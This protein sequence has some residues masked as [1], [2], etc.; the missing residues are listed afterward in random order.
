MPSPRSVRP[1]ALFSMAVAMAACGESAPPATDAGVDA[2]GSPTEFEDAAAGD[3]GSHDAGEPIDAPTDEGD[4]MTMD[5]GL[6]VGSALDGAGC[7]GTETC[8]VFDDDCDGRIDETACVP[9]TSALRT[10]CT[11]QRLADG[12]VLLA[13]SSSARLDG[14]DYASRFCEELGAGYVAATIDTAS[15]PARFAGS[16]GTARGTFY[17]PIFRLADGTFVDE[18]GTP[19]D[20]TSI[21]ALEWVDGA[22]GAVSLQRRCT[23]LHDDGLLEDVPCIALSYDH[24]AL[25]IGTPP[26]SAPSCTPATE[27]CDGLDDDCDLRVDERACDECTPANFLGHRYAMCAFGQ[28]ETSLRRNYQNA[29]ADCR[30]RGGSLVTFET[31]DE[32]VAVARRLRIDPSSPY[33][34]YTR[35][36]SDGGVWTTSEGLPAE[37]IFWAL[38][39]PDSDDDCAGLA[40]QRSG[41]NDVTCVARRSY[42]CELGELVGP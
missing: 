18:L 37:T 29:L 16:L 2:G 17:V 25:C 5:G 40:A 39:D 10:P 42:G 26:T 13:C 28:S 7:G 9:A 31:R 6:P 23:V 21:A 35:L 11:T 36:L 3:A 12:R 41:V 1:F 19:L 22:P 14:I 30:G 33:V 32:L 8:N 38:G 34:G 24:G 27:T 20:P 15:D 4:A